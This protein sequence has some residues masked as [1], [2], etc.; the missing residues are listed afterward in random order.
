M[1]LR[2]IFIPE[3]GEA[4]SVFV[5]KILILSAAA[6]FCICLVA[7]MILISKPET[8]EEIIYTEGTTPKIITTTTTAPPVTTAETTTTLPPLVM[9]EE[10]YA[11]LIEKNPD[12]AGWVKVSDIIDQ[13][14]LQTTDNEKYLD[15]DFDLNYNIGGSVYVDYRCNVNDYPDKMS[16]NIVVYGHNQRDGT[17]FGK[18]KNYKITKANPKNIDY[19]KEHPTF[20]FSNLYDTYTYKIVA[21][22]VTEVEPRHNPA[23][24]IF[25]YHNYIKFNRVVEEP[26]TYDTWE[27]Q[28]LSHSAIITGVDIE[29]GDK[30]LTLSTC[31]NEF[32]PSRLVVIG[33]RLRE[34]ESAEV[35][36]SKAELNPDAIEPNWAYIYNNS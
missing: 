33:R 13:V 15:K 6:V 21:I 11:E 10:K 34:N 25:D 26:Y 8:A 32:E 9:N 27:K 3:K 29:K 31:S 2:K 24:E 12:T 16:D 23:G 35:D 22:F 19:Y 28:I 36:T 30:F 14:V 18:L 7:V 1:D 4:K 5:R 17:A 20:E